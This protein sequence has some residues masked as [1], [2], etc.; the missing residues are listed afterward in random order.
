MLRR[1]IKRLRGEI[2]GA[3]SSSAR[4]V[5]K[6]CKGRKDYGENKRHES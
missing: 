2:N 6:M 5:S 4:E 3:D 1:K